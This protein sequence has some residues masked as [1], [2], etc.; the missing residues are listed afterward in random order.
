MPAHAKIT[1]IQYLLD[2]WQAISLPLICEELR[3]F[4]S[5]HKIADAIKTGD[6]HSLNAWLAQ[7]MDKLFGVALIDNGN[8]PEYLPNVNGRAQLGFAHGYSASALHE[9]SHWTLAGKQRR[10]L[11]DFGYW[12]IP[13]GRD[14]S[15]QLKFEQFEVKPQAIECLLCVALG[16]PFYPSKD[17][18]SGI[19]T[20]DNF[21]NAVFT[22]AKLYAN[23]PMQLP[24][25]AF[26]FIH[27]IRYA[28]GHSPYQA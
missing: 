4:W 17:N 15:A 1:Q 28:H 18:L 19:D 8:E 7:A 25:D 3:A 16:T 21:E 9:I 27:S 23:A 5:K 11:V 13:D 26:L 24:A 20:G 22:Q 6:D 2:S 10:T 12:Y 14:Y